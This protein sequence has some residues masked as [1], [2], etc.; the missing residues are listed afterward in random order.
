MNLTSLNEY[1][2]S[3]TDAGQFSGVVRITQG[4]QE[5]YAGAFGYACRPWKIPNSLDIR[6]DTAS[7][8]KLF[9][10]VSILQLIDQGKLTFETSAINFLGL[11]DTQISEKVTVYHL[12]THTSGIGDDAEEED[13]ELYEDLWKSKPNYMVTETRDFLPQ[14]IHKPPNFP[15][16]QGCRYCNCSFILLGLMIEQITGMTYRDYVRQH[17]FT[18]AGMTQSDFLRMDRVHENV[19]EGADPIRDESDQITGWKKN[20]YSFPPV[21][22][23]DAGAQVT[24]VDL[25]NFLRAV[26]AGKL[27]SP[28]LTEAFLTPQVHYKDHDDWTQLYGHVFWFYV[29]KSGGVVCYQKE[30][31]NAGVSGVMRYFPKSDIN[32]VI[33]CNM[34]DGVWEPIWK[35]HEMIT[36]M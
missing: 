1:L 22:S 13:G 19:A 20:F 15:P 7:I 4:K 27:L 10:A 21:G 23:P 30:G 31:I 6:F 8:T 17:V 9:T 5:L 24:A 36:S 35:I 3:R 16:G 11:R 2:Q 32:V 33:L 34:E 14:F 29:N 25:D 28:E 12:L 18:P 26:Q